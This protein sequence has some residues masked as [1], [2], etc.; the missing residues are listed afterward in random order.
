VPGARCAV[1]CA[2]CRVRCAR[3]HLRGA[4]C[5]VPGGRCLVQWAARLA[6]LLLASGALVAK[7]GDVVGSRHDLSVRGGAASKATTETQSCVFCHTPHNSNPARQLWNHQASAATYA[8]YGS[9]SFQSGSSGG[10]YNTF[11]GTSAGQPTG[12]AKLCLSCHDGTVATNATINDGTIAMGGSTFVPASS[13]LGTDLSNDHPVSFARNA[14]NTQVT[15]PPAG[16]AVHLETTTRYVQCVACHDAHT[17]RI[18]ATTGKFL[19]KVNKASAMCVTCHRKSGTAWSWASSSHA[20]SV[21]SYTS[22]S[23]GGVAG[24]GAHTGYTTVAD[25]GCEA[26]H[27]PHSAPQAQR[28][29]KAVNQRDVCFQCH[30]NTAV[31][32]KNIATVMAKTYRHPVETS[33]ATILHDATEV[34]TSPTNFSGAR[35]HVDCADCHNAH[36]AAAGLHVAGTNQV[37]AGVLAGVPGVEPSAYPAVLALTGSY[38]MTSVAQTSYNVANPSAREYQICFK[39]HSSYAYGTA[40]PNAPSGGPETDVA[41]E[42]NPNNRSYHPVV[43]APHLRVPA[44]NLLAPWNTTTASTRMYCT[45]CHGNNDATSATV[46]QG[47]HGSSNPYMLRFSNATWSTTA[48][49]LTTGSGFCFNCHSAATIRSANRV[50]D[51]GSH[52]SR[53]C[54]A[55]HAATPHGSFRPGLI[56]LSSDPAPYNMGASRLT[57]FTQASTPSGYAM[58]NCS[59]ASGCH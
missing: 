2:R 59:T 34:R 6:C 52:Q 17:E 32:A 19:V 20:V 8:T 44:S 53:P 11:A 15:D 30:G 14:S 9:S 12:S 37:V 36:G 55:C 25:N 26:C 41:S 45:D 31:A 3:C 23:T 27:R 57:S 18:D 24:L 39:C 58:S 50:H 47:A 16:D 38:P 22:A 28:L 43:G 13:N 54:Q 21:K 48:P 7:P 29:L 49:T 46:P 51:V 1:P 33:T 10:T 40:R 42:V 5:R 35:R 4:T 56:A